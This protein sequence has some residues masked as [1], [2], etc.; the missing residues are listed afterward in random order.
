M[1]TGFA[2][3]GPG[4]V[5]R[6]CGRAPLPSIFRIRRQ[7]PP[8]P[9]PDATHPPLLPPVPCSYARTLA[10]PHGTRLIWKTTSVPEWDVAPAR[11]NE[12][13][14]R[15]AREHGFEVCSMR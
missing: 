9:S 6:N 5:A 1:E 11:M 3:E 12:V 8:A 13:V 7:T 4:Y 14:A 10:E 15:L 2:F